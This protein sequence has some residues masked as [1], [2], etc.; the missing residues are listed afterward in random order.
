MR[1]LY[2]DTDSVI[3]VQKTDEPPLIDC[4]DALDNMTSELKANEYI[5]VFVSGGPKNYAYKICNSVTGEVKTVCN[6][7]RITLNYKAS[8]RVNFD[9]I[10][11]FVLNE[12]SDSNVSSN[13]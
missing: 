4:G 11:D 3:F 8:K 2:C 12:R 7:R 9:T 6:V 13:G 1:A 5:S 10:K